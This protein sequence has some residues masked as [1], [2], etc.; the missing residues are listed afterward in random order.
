MVN[1]QGGNCKDL[2]LS[3]WQRTSRSPSVWTPGPSRS[4]FISS[5]FRSSCSWWEGL[6]VS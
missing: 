5:A 3:H 4:K 2:S 6:C 1:N